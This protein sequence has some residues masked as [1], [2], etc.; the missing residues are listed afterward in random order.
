[1]RRYR[2]RHLKR[3]PKRRGPVVVATA[4]T[5]SLSGAAQAGTYVVRRGD[6]LS[7]IAA[8]TSTTVTALARLNQLENEN[9]I[10]A[11]QRLRLRGGSHVHVVRSGETLSGIAARYGTSVSALARVN[12]LRNPDIIVVGTR[13]RV[14]RGG[15][16]SYAPAPPTAPSIAGSLDAHARTHGV[17]PSL[18]KAIAWQESGWHQDVRSSAG[19]IGVMQVMPATGRWVNT[20]LGGNGL[21]IHVA[22]DNV[23]LGVMYLRHL[24]D[25]MGSVRRAVAAYYSGPGSVGRR[26]DHGQRAYADNVLALMERF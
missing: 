22:D 12:R 20:T 18:V 11:G 2:A 25:Q 7:G 16:G 15:G 6:T 8:R 9:L 1:M 14:P 10:V 5:M 21:N 4:A 24:L 19:A 3:R 23:H 13:L 17:D 26:L